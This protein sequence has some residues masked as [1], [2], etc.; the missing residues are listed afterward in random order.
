MREI[1]SLSVQATS[2][3]GFTRAE[4]AD[5]KSTP[6][7]I[8]RREQLASQFEGM[9]VSMLLKEMRS[10]LEGGLFSGE[11]SDTYGALFDMYLGEHLAGGNGLGVR[12]LL[13]NQW[14]SREDLVA[15]SGDGGADGPEQES[16]HQVR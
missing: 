2:G 11:G 5:L 4:H 12:E 9:F 1:P 15:A 7:D 16:K 6:A 8:H 10:S 13:L 14:K 3:L